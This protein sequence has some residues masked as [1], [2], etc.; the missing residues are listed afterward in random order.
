MAGFRLSAEAESELDDIWLYTANASGSVE[1]AHRVI[2]NITDRF[3]LLA[4]HPYLGR[5]RDEDLS[6]GLRSLN[7]DEYVIIHR[8]GND[9][10]VLILHVLHGSRDISAFFAG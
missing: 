5:R 4:Q 2:D 8:V 3:W 10:V 6:P 1:I 7:A 9:G